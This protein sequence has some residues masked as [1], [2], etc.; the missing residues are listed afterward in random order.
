MFFKKIFIGILHSGELRTI[1]NIKSNYEAYTVNGAE[2]K[3]MSKFKNVINKC[4]LEEDEDTYVL[5]LIPISELHHMMKVTTSLC[6]I[7]R[8]DNSVKEFWKMQRIFWH[9]QRTKENVPWK[10]MKNVRWTDSRNRFLSVAVL[11]FS[12]CQQQAV[13]VRFFVYFH[14]LV[15]ICLLLHIEPGR[16]FETFICTQFY[17]TKETFYMVSHINK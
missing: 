12:W 3:D 4:L 17:Y 6:D 9:G 8:L 11:P 14:D 2:K 7:L 10:S 13:N 5:D 15:P 16:I 1:G